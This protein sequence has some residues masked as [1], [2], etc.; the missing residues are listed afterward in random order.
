[1]GKKEDH[2]NNMEFLLNGIE[3]L[4]QRYKTSKQKTTTS[5]NDNTCYDNDSNDEK[6]KHTKNTVSHWY[7]IDNAD[8]ILEDNRKKNHK[9]QEKMNDGIT[10][11]KNET[12]WY[13]ISNTSDDDNNE[14]IEVTKT[15]FKKK[16]SDQEQNKKTS[17]NLLRKWK[18][19]ATTSESDLENNR[20]HKQQQKSKNSSSF[21]NQKS[22]INRAEN[23]SRRIDI[24][25]T[26]SDSDSD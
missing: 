19:I 16:S 23:Q 9:H 22:N 2:D 14:E 3:E 1:M 20:Y 15:Q 26:I 13:K 4:I 12:R 6:H 24:T 18:K 11:R 5:N 10:S 7:R 8:Q 25:N 17:D 21:D